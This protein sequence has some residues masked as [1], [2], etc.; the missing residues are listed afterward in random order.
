MLLLSLLS[1]VSAKDLGN[2]VGVGFVVQ[3]LPALSVRYGLPTGS[4]IINVQIEADL[5]LSLP[6]YEDARYLGGGRLLYGVVAEDNMNFYLG[7]GAGYYK[8][9]ESGYARITPCGSFQFFLFGLENLGISADFGVNLDIGDGGTI[10][11]FGTFPAGG[12][13]YY[14]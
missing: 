5:G 7:A 1:L 3:D 10:S 13:H 12:L 8:E 4:P 14:F 9:G 2:R 6:A 11:T